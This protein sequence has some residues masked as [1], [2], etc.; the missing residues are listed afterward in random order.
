MAWDLIAEL[1]PIVGPAHVLTGADMARYANDWTGQISRRTPG[2][3]APGSTAEVAA[4][5]QGR[6]AAGVPVVASGGRTG[7]VGGRDDHGGLMLSLERMNRIREI[8]PEARL[9]VVE[10]GVILRACTMRPR[11]R[12]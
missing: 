7:L 8:K 2:R 12:A 1:Q 10:A 3:G 5:R 9:A 11:R 6:G 4:V